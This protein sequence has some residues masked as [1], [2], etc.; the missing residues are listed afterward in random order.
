L[1]QFWTHFY[2]K[3]KWKAEYI[4]KVIKKQEEERE[5]KE[6]ERFAEKQETISEKLKSKKDLVCN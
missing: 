3:I 5:R 2:K 1:G 4:E 6:N